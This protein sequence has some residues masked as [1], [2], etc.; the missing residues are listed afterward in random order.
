M[1]VYLLGVT[2]SNSFTAE[3]DGRHAQLE[4]REQEWRPFLNQVHA[5]RVYLLGVTLSNSFTAEYDGR[6]TQLEA[7]THLGEL[8]LLL[9]LLLPAVFTG[10]PAPR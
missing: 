6:H 1:R 9:F 5:L 8:C 4:A 7:R 2:L 10:T 3:Y